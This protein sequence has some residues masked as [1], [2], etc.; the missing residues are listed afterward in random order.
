[1]QMTTNI[2][3]DL[4]DLITREREALL[5]QWR[6]QIRQLPSASHLDIPTLNDHVPGLLVEIAAA[7]RLKSD[8]TIPEA[9]SEGTPPAHGVQRLQDGFDLVEVVAEYNILRGC[10]HDLAEA[11]GL[12]LEGTRFHILNRVLDAAIGPAVEAY[13]TKRALDVQQRREDYLMFVMHDLRTPLNAIALASRLLET[14]ITTAS[15]AVDTAQIFV[16]L[17]RNIGQLERLVAKVIEENANL[18]TEVGIK[19]VRRELDLWPIV[20]ALI[21]D[22]HPVA[23][24][25]S[26]EL[27]NEVPQD[28]TVYADAGL[29]TRVFQNLIAN[30]ISY[31]PRGRVVIGARTLPADGHVECWVSDNGAGIPADLLDKVFDKFEADPEK[32]GRLG[33][34]LTIVKTFVEAH[35]GTVSVESH[36]GRG[37]AF[38]FF[39]TPKPDAPPA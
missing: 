13:A 6:Q 34:G 39:L 38:R 9:L 16:T 12:R 2:G 35:D 5:S 20:E 4:A 1:M 36:E 31:T 33:L 3:D 29:L 21:H 19:V 27:V 23:G 22:L 11:N 7:L 15:A 25:S 37:A 17:R 18:Q 32:P 14:Q 26:T 10:V 24:T 28:L 8:E 30:A